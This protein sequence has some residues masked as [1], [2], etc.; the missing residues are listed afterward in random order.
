VIVIGGGLA[1]MAACVHLAKAGFQVLCIE[2]DKD[3]SEAVGESLDW[4]APDLLKALGLPKEYLISEQI[5]T[6]KRHVILK[7]EDGSERHYI[8]SDWLGRPPFNIDLATLHVDRTRLDEALREVVRSHG[9]ETIFEKVV[10][11][12][13]DGRRVAA[14]KTAADKW[15][16]GVTSR[17][18]RSAKAPRFIRAGRS[19]TTW[20]GSGKFRFDRTPSAWDTLREGTISRPSVNRGRR[21]RTSFDLNCRGSRASRRYWPPGKEYAPA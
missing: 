6:Y 7:L 21:L 15:L 8:P 2:H 12:E 19:L 20:I 3:F 11:V 5:A 10:E 14:V 17:S 9:V 1:G 13:G 4:S 16:F 18:Q